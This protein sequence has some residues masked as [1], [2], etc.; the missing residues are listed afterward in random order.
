MRN[1][2]LFSYRYKNIQN[3]IHHNKPDTEYNIIVS[4]APAFAKKQVSTGLND[5]QFTS[6]WVDTTFN[7]LDTEK[8]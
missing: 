6:V 8:H 3:A 2:N 7:G 5:F 1:S 4:I